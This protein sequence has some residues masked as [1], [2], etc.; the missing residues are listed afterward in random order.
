MK[1][2]RSEIARSCHEDAEA[3]FRVGAIDAKQM[4]EYDVHCLVSSRVPIRE[5][6][7]YSGDSRSSTRI[8]AVAAA[9]A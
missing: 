6:S 1:K 2:Y 3:M 7:S 8:S 4:H 5:T 9:R